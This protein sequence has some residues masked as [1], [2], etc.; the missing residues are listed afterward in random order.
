[1]AKILCVLYDDPV[2]GYPPQYP[3]AEIPKIERYPDG[4]ATP[5]PSA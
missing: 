2:D 3:R 1:M 4:Q 5:T